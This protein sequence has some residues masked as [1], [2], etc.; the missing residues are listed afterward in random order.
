MTHS[1]SMLI[2][3]LVAVLLALTIGYCTIL[4]NRLKR[5]R[6]D[7]KALRGMIA[8]LVGATESAERA[9]AGLKLTVQDSDQ[10][11][12]DRLRTAERLSAALDVQ[13]EHGEKLL[14][15]VSGMSGVAA[16]LERRPE[17]PLPDAKAMVAAA[18]AF[19]ERARSRVIGRAA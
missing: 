19:A 2:E 3:G 16:A 9:I 5:L 6:T 17:P 10:T 1:L 11:L 4:N 18:N 13:I 15:G 8:E 14:V 7:E 12:G